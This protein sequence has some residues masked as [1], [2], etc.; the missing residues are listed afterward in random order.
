MGASNTRELGGTS[1]SFDDF[2]RFFIHYRP[3]KPST[4]ALASAMKVLADRSLKLEDALLMGDEHFKSKEEARNALSR[5]AACDP[6]FGLE[7]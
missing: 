5:L 1:V 7:N 2:I 4:A 6:G 3:V